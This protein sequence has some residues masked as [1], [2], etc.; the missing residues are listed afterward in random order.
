MGAKDWISFLGTWLRMVE[1]T[2]TGE[3]EKWPLRGGLGEEVYVG[4]GGL[5]GAK[6]YKRR[7]HEVV[8]KAQHKSNE[9]EMRMRPGL[10]L[11]TPL[12]T[13]QGFSD[14]L[15]E[16]ESFIQAGGSAEV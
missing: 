3:G 2:K 6:A 13:Q 12:C 7:G 10:V 8:A 16:L 4:E 14:R 15:W 5:A 9:G 1:V 11:F